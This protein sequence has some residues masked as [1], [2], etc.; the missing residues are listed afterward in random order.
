MT[1]SAA[2]YP[3]IISNNG[4]GWGASKYQ[5]WFRHM[6]GWGVIVVGNEEPTTWDGKATQT[7]L[8]WILSLD[9]DP[10]S[11]FHNHIDR[12][13]I[14]TIGHSQGG[15]GVI[16]S[17]TAIA[18]HDIFKTAVILASSF[19][20]YS[21]F[22]KWD[23]DASKIRIPTLILAAK[24][25][26]LTPEADLRKLYGAIPDSTFAVMGR[27]LNCGHGDM[28]VFAD[29]YVTA[30]MMWQ[31]KGDSIAARAFIGPEPELASDS[32][33]IDVLIR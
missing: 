21:S 31:L 16:N 27:R 19:N 3:L 6:A 1:S 23:C 30:W 5:E 29:G 4:T 15:T 18:A 10:A 17:V 14:A 24:E 2:K 20:G 12:A 8:E 9:A 11:L 22:L 26:A 33:F 28:L 13:R 25:D 32:C 7:S